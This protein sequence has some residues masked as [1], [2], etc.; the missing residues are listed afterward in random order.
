[1]S[2]STDGITNWM[3]LF[4]WIVKLIRDEYGV[5]E[6]ILT[7]TAVLETDC[8]LTIEQLEQ[9]LEYLSDSF[10]ITF[11][12][13]TLD[14]VLKLEELCLLASWLKGFYKRPEFISGEFEAICR[15][16]NPGAAP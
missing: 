2:L 6:K 4:R 8:G 11:P 10:S 14:Q 12:E 3:H 16:A 13:G 7:R 1:M 15:A 9:V 5:D